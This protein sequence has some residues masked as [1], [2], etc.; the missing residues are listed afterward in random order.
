MFNTELIRAVC[1]T[2]ILEAPAYKD[3]PLESSLAVEYLF[4]LA[5]SDSSSGYPA[6]E[7]IH[8]VVSYILEQRPQDKKRRIEYIRMLC[9]LI[10]VDNPDYVNYEG[11]KQIFS[12]HHV[13]TRID[14][15]GH[16]P[17]H[18][19]LAAATRFG[20]TSLVETML[21]AGVK[22]SRISFLG[23]S[24]IRAVQCDNLYLTGLLLGSQEC[25]YDVPTAI[26]QAARNGNDATVQLL[27]QGKDIHK[28]RDEY[29]Y[30]CGFR[31]AAA[32]GQLKTLLYLF[33]SAFAYYQIDDLSALNDKICDS[34]RRHICNEIPLQAALH[35]HEEVV[36]YIL[37][38]GGNLC[39]V[40]K[41]RFAKWKNSLDAA[42]WKGHEGVVRILLKRG[43]TNKYSRFLPRSLYLAARGGWVRIAQ[44]LID[45]GATINMEVYSYKETSPLLGAVKYGQP[46]MVRFLLDIKDAG[47]K[48]DSDVCKEAYSMAVSRGYTSIVTYFVERN[49]VL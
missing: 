2:K 19:C 8:Q 38:N 25:E 41:F 16:N 44:I 15:Q 20:M 35:G 5:K 13:L 4:M 43:W 31:G 49:L 9:G 10:V 36:E 30:L 17:D 11:R 28:D 26:A 45:Y 1:S 32:G 37:D 34:T 12:I 48:A 6:V 18:N 21:E 23:P 24:L 40:P 14:S 27:L 22:E 33:Q 47:W 3:R 7:V 29:M 39:G 46:D 42:V